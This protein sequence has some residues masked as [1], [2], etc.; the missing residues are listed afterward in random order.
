[1]R[2]P[3]S[4]PDVNALLKSLKPERLVEIVTSGAGRM[5]SGDY[6][7]WDKL[8]YKPPPSGLSNP[9]W[10][11]ATKFARQSVA[12]PLPFTG[13]DGTP[14]WFSDHPDMYRQLHEIDQNASGNIEVPSPHMANK[15][16][17]ERYVMRS[18]VEEAITSS[19]LEGAATTRVVAREML[20][21]GRLPRDISERMIANNYHAMEFIR[22]HGGEDLSTGALVELQRL[23][24]EG[25]LAPSAVGR[26]RNSGDDIH[27]VDAEGNLLHTPPDA[28]ELETR[29]AT[30]IDF[31]NGRD[32]SQF[33]HPVVRAIILHF[34]IGYD[35]PFVDGNGRTARALFYWS[36]ARSGYWL[37]EYISISRFIRRSYASY[38]RAYLYTEN[39]ENDVTYFLNYNLRVIKQ[40][41]D[42][43][44]NYLA[45][46]LSET[47]RLER[48]FN[49]GDLSHYLNHRQKA[50]LAH[51][52][53]HPDAVYTI[54]AHRRSNNVSYHTA[55]KDLDE[56]ASFKFLT[57][58]TRR[59]RKLLFQMNP[60]FSEHLRQ[61]VDLLA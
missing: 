21:S 16:T 2:I 15:G 43:L 41:I 3:K 24:T 19:Q 45:R 47:R 32:A 38:G 34:M 26:F 18:L 56:L 6:L 51:M 57:R 28:C 8:R 5:P 52:V 50:L 29:V 48:M 44:H 54:E 37:M 46:K 49:E 20:R 27:V 60:S 11:L 58:S 33:I 39:D 30:L 59:G 1:M 31:A 40:C 36:M 61:I 13:K 10:W 7:H 53:N 17:R 35:H 4:P 22:D 55:R 14:F 12:H 23:L 42:D 25:T 9:E